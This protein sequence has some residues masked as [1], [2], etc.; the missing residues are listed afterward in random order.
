M[1]VEDITNP[2]EYIECIIAFDVRDWCSD[3]RLSA[4]YCIVFGMSD[5]GYRE[6]Q[7]KYQ[8]SDTAIDRLKK[9]HEK[10]VRLRKEE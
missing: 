8:W 4:I 2:L 3:S 5:D 9:F 1:G 6:L 10:W 7:D